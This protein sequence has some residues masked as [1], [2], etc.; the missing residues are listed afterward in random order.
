VKTVLHTLHGELL[1][2]A[3]IPDATRAVVRSVDSTDLVQA[4]V[5]GLMVNTF[6]LSGSPGVSAVAS[7]GGVHSFMGWRGPVAADSGGFQVFSLLSENPALGSVTDRGFIYR[8]ARGG[9]K[10]TLT[11]EKCI[12]RQFRMGVDIMFCL[13]YCTHPVAPTRVQ[14]ESVRLTVEWARRCKDTFLR[15]VDQRR[16]GDHERP[17]LYAVVQ[18]GNDREL[19]RFCADQLVDMGF[20]GYGYGGWPIADDG[21]LVD[22]VGMVAELTPGEAPRHALGIGKPESV[23]RAAAMGYDTFDVVIPTRDARHKRLYIAC[24]DFAS[25]TWKAQDFYENLYIHD[26]SFA[27]DRRPVEESC[28]CVCCRNYSRAYLRHLFDIGDSLAPRLATIHNL[29]F[30]T[31]LMSRIREMLK[32]DQ[33]GQDDGRH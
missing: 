6:H 14:S 26:A 31:R 24:D 32:G 28:D 30:Y 19:R 15:Q 17:L 25:L 29:R 7:V 18:G 33:C 21:Q 20:D 23:V 12:E 13:D 27:R 9:A 11:P 5:P 3:F 2:P 4:H 8:R 10:Q 16:L 22:S 1:L